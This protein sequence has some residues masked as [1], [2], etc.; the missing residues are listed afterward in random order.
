ML[1]A[2][3]ERRLGIA[4][5]LAR[6]MPDRRDPARVTHTLADMIRARIFVTAMGYEDADDLDQLRRDPPFK[7][8][9]G[10]LPDTGA[11]LCS[12]PTLS[13]LENAPG[14]RDVIRLTYALV[15]AWMDFYPRPPRS[16]A[17]FSTL[18]SASSASSATRRFR[19]KSST[20]RA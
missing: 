2:M 5:R 19:S 8:A 13:R 17:A 18:C 6:L 10:R 7:L 3:A 11:D 20:R 12:Q 16:S 14:L 15:D 4:S 9:C 1:L